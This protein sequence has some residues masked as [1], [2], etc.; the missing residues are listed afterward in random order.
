MNLVG[1]VLVKNYDGTQPFTLETGLTF[2]PIYDPEAPL[3]PPSTTASTGSV[4]G[5][6]TGGAD[7]EEDGGGDA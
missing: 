6:T 5:F 3:G 7:D 1:Y 2:P 4:G